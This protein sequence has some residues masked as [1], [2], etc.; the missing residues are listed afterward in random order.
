M[1][2][3]PRLGAI[4]TPNATIVPNATTR[5]EASPRSIGDLEG[6]SPLLNPPGVTFCANGGGKKARK[7]A[8]ALARA[9]NRT[10]GFPLRAPALG[11]DLAISEKSRMGGEG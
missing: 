10:Y 3:L 2:T 8:P 5:Q 11:E 4:P 9:S 1:R 7:R 6:S